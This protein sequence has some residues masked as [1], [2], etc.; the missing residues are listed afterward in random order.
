MICRE[1][2]MTPALPPRADFAPPRPRS[3][4][5]VR[6]RTGCR[7]GGLRTR[8][9]RPTTSCLDCGLS[10]PRGW[11]PQ[12]GGYLPSQWAHGNVRTRCEAAIADRGH[13]GAIGETCHLTDTTKNASFRR[14]R[15]AKFTSTRIRA[16]GS[17]AGSSPGCRLRRIS[18]SRR[19]AS[20]RS[21]IFVLRR[22]SYRF[23]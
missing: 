8:R 22:P 18:E 11:T 20:A 6:T 4:S 7:P 5:D 9:K 13:T 17:I 3:K 19:R 1:G 23:R 12:L 15:L 21:S 10:R 16:G 14:K 2:Q